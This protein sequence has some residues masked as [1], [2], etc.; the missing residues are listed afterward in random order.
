MLWAH[1]AVLVHAASPRPGEAI[2]DVGCGAGGTVLAIAEAVAR[3]QRLVGIDVSGPLL[4]RASSRASRAGVR[5]AFVWADAGRHPFLSPT[6]DLL[7][8][9]LG[10]MFFD[11]PVAAFGR[12][13]ETLRPGGRL[14]CLAWRSAGENEGAS[15][16]LR[17][18]RRILPLLA[19]ASPD[20][21]GPF[22]FGDRNTME[23]RLRDAG[24][25]EIRVEP[26]DAPLL[27]GVGRTE[28]DALDDAVQMAFHLRPLRRL[29]GD[30]PESVRRAVRQDVRDAFAARLTR[31]GVLLSSAAWIVSARVGESA[32]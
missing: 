22:S 26:F 20:A 3:A 14:V 16:P 7:V 30:E 8:S 9:R 25:V 19:P 17:A 2:L 12:L 11:D 23:Q 6:F 13:R 31:E 28:D 32:R 4:Q 10:V 15:L 29:L 24:F 1:T 5:A 18:A 21:P 27:F